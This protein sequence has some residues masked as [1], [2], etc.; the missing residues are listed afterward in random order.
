MYFNIRLTL[1]QKFF[2]NWARLGPAMFTLHC[3][4]CR[5]VEIAKQKKKKKKREKEGGGRLTWRWLAAVL[6]VATGKAD[7]GSSSFLFCFLFFSSRFPPI[8]S[9][10][11]CFCFF[12][13]FPVVFPLSNVLSSSVSFCF[14]L[15]PLSAFYL[16]KLFF[17]S[18]LSISLCFSS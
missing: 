10:F 7:G 3:S 1:A 15:P 6:V 4:F 9:F 13:F 18:T 5:T 14:V 12:L 2:F 8:I 17:F 16:E 11:R